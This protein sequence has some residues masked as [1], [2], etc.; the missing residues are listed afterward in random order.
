MVGARLPLL[1]HARKIPS[2][3]WLRSKTYFFAMTNFIRYYYCCR[4]RCCFLFC[5]RKSPPLLFISVQ[6]CCHFLLS[7]FGGKKEWRHRG[8]CFFFFFLFFYLSL[9]IVVDNEVC[10]W[11]YLL[12]CFCCLSVDFII[13]NV[14]SV[15]YTFFLFFPSFLHDSATLSTLFI[16]Q[17]CENTHTPVW[18]PC[19]QPWPSENHLPLFFYLLLQSFP[20]NVK[21]SC[22]LPL[23]FFFRRDREKKSH[24][25][26]KRR[27]KTLTFVDETFSWFSLHFFWGICLTFRCVQY[28]ILE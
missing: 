1:S 20:Y 27:K 13:A 11:D 6:I 2:L 24:C 4:R 8:V 12:V 7:N 28:E 17:S 25:S 15:V 18:S 22:S 3:L 9:F 19:F 14:G 26:K 10:V 16:F 23:L 5:F 21:P